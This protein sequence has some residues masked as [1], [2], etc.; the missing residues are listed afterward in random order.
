VYRPNGTSEIL[1]LEVKSGGARL[2]QQQLVTLVQAVRTGQV[3]L[4]NE[5]AAKK[6]G[7]RPYETFAS[8][9]IIPFVYVSGGNRDAITRQL[10]KLGIDAVPENT[11]RGQ[12]PRLRLRIRPT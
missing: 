11:R 9:G 5:E 6:F 2:S 7:L 8:K 3:Y 1:I 12:V 10:N 4:V